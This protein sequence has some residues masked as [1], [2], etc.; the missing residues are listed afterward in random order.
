MI[1]FH[2]KYFIESIAFENVNP[3]Q[4]R[5][6]NIK[7]RN[8]QK[9]ENKLT[10]FQVYHETEFHVNIKIHSTKHNIQKYLSNTT[11]VSI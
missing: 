5:H 3:S 2:K 11:K 1:K 6:H 8:I 10:L 9:I 7:F 4:I